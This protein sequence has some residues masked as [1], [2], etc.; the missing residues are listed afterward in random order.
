MLKRSLL[1]SILIS[2]MSMGVVALE[3]IPPI[4]KRN[5]FDSQSIAL[6]NLYNLYFEELQEASPEFAT[7][8]GSTK[9]NDSWTNYS[10][11][12][13]VQRQ[14]KIRKI[15]NI[16]LSF[17]REELSNEEQLNYDLFSELLSEAIEEYRLKFRYMAVDQLSGVP[18]DVT[19]T[20]MM[21]PKNS[22]KDYKDILARLRALPYLLGQIEKLLSIGL[23]KGISQPR[24][25]LRSLPMRLENLIPEK[26]EKS[27]FFLPFT[28]FPDSFTE[29]EITDLKNEATEILSSSVYPAYQQFLNYIR[30]VYLERCRTSIGM[31]DLPNGQEQYNYLVKSFTTTDLTPA[32]IHEIGLTE[33]CRIKAE[34]QAI[35]DD[36]GFEGTREEFMEHLHHN[37]KFFYDTAEDLVEGYREITRYIDQQLPTIFGKMPKLPYEVLAVPAH[38]EGSQIGAYY[39]PGSPKTGRPG[40]FYVNTFDLPSRPKWTMESLA[41]HESVPG[42]H[43][44]I[45][46]AQEM[47]NVPEFRKYTRYTSYIEGWALYCEGLG[48]ELGLYRSPYSKFGRLVEEIWRAVRLVVDTGMH[49]MGWSREEAIA[50][51]IEQTGI[52]ER[53]ATTEIDRYIV[54][55]GQALAYKIGELCFKKLR[56]LAENELGKDFDIRAFHDELLSRGALPMGMCEKIMHRWIEE[57][58][59]ELCEMKAS[60]D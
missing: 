45:A 40:V 3:E 44:Q 46:I 2:C 7:Y 24:I 17:D 32:Q 51:F 14:I 11:H 50:Y 49:S 37:P 13:Y 16:F 6:R 47:E 58:K 36:L 29:Q 20:L 33:V 39:M 43:F 57:Q 35:M 55:P 26:F 30:E 34:M 1:Y 5:L 22:L 21:M 4:T 25:C 9:Y 54:W 59:I 60:P 10:E 19:S 23:E 27:P 48:E 41:L 56:A 12:A 38:S 52:G 53:E 18:L 31:C 42:H 15:K 28:N 8:V